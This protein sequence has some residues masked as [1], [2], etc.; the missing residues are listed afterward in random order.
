MAKKIEIEMT[1][2]ASAF[3]D[4]VIAIYESRRRAVQEVRATM[5]KENEATTSAWRKDA[6]R[7]GRA[8][9]DEAR[10]SPCTLGEC[11]VYHTHLPEVLPE[12]SREEH[13]ARMLE[14]GAATALRTMM[15][16]PDGP[17]DLQLQFYHRELGAVPYVPHLHELGSVDDVSSRVVSS[18]HR[19]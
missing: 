7:G 14:L 18:R 4:S 2:Q 16:V 10:P 5:E 17:I 13:A 8:L 11:V 15:R 6:V 1:S 19:P 9:A 3:L 12:L